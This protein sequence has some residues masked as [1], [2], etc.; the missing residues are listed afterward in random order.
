MGIRD[1]IHHQQRHE[2]EQR[3]PAQMRDQ[4]G[5]AHQDGEGEGGQPQSQ[6]NLAHG[7][8]NIDFIFVNLGQQSQRL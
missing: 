2:A 7:R 8:T 1:R 6:L 5:N 4:E 3:H